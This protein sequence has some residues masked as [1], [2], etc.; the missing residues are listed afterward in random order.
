MQ[1][2]EVIVGAG[3]VLVV[4][5]DVFQ[6]VV[7]PRPTPAVFRP[8]SGIIGALWLLTFRLALRL[9]DS[10][11]RELVL[12][13]FA[14]FI[15]VVLLVAWVVLLIGGYGLMLFAL[16]S[17][18]RPVPDGLDTTLY[19]SGVALLTLGFGDFV[20]VG[21]AARV[22]VLM[23]AGTGLGIVALVIT[24]LFTL[25]GAYQ[26]RETL[27]IS[28]SARA[29]APPSGLVLLETY[30]RYAMVADLAQ[31]FANWEAWA[32]EVLDSH[33]S[34]PLL[35]YFR[36][37]HDSQSW[38]S[39][40]GAVLDAACL[41]TTTIDGGPSGPAYLFKSV[42]IHLVAD[43]GQ[44]FRL[45]ANDDTYVEESEFVAVRERLLS[46][47]YR[48]ENEARSWASFSR[49]RAQYAGVLNAMARRWA[50]PPALWIGD[51]SRL[52]PHP[53]KVGGR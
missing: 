37:T 35:A 11:R 44:Y 25:F 21:G 18:L 2:L 1:A 27:I 6:T 45:D 8:S 43:L 13:M 9:R 10:A 29:G 41:V 14:P 39:A 52:R 48:L 24:F 47:G 5:F 50:T 34:Y 53:H 16:R 4:L 22:I 15:V 33:L 46:A 12:G 19:F 30:A 23:E 26:R 49:A 7:L 40:L 42:G 31:V 3:I 36:S 32:A 28:L 20:A 38:I 51:R 17:G